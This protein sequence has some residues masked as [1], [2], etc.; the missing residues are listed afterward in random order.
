MPFPST[1]TSQQKT[2]IRTLGYKRKAYVLA[3][4]KSIVFQ[5]TVK[6]AI[7]D[8]DYAEVEFDTP[9]TGAYTDIV[10]GQTV[11]VHT[12]S[13]DIDDIVSG[14]YPTFAREAATS[15]AVKTGWLATDLAG[16]DTITVLDDYRL[17][18]RQVRVDETT[19][20]VYLDYDDEWFALPP[21]IH[22]LQSVYVVNSSAASSI[23]F[24]PTV[25]AMASGASISTY[26]WDVGDGTITVGASN[27]KDITVEFPA[28]TSGA[29]DG[30]R[31][32]S[33]TVTDDNGNSITFHFQVFVGDLESASWVVQD[34]IRLDI[35]SELEDGFIG[36]L[37]V[38][39]TATSF[40]DNQHI[41]VAI[42]ETKNSDSDPIVSNIAFVGRLKGL[43]DDVTASL[44][45]T[46]STVSVDYSTSYE[47]QGYGIELSLLPMPEYQL[48]FSSAASD[49]NQVTD[50]SVSR[51]I[52]YA[53]VHL[54]T[55]TTVISFDLDT[56]TWNDYQ[57]AGFSLEQG[58]A[59]ESI[60]HIG[61]L[62]GA[63]MVFARSGEMV[64][65]Q[66]ARLQ[67]TSDRNGLT[68]VTDITSD[69]VQGMRLTVPP[70]PRVGRVE[71]TGAS[72]N[73]SAEKG[74]F[75]RAI[76]PKIPNTTGESVR[77]FDVL[78]DADPADTDATLAELAIITANLLART[79]QAIQVDVTGLLDGYW[80]LIAHNGQW[81]T[82]TYDGF[83]SGKSYDSNTRWILISISLS[84]EVQTDDNGIPYQSWSVGIALSVETSDS[85][86][87]NS[88]VWAPDVQPYDVP[89]MSFMAPYGSDYDPSNA[90]EDANAE[91]L[92]ED[93]GA[94]EGAQPVNPPDSEP[95]ATPSKDVISVPLDGTTVVMN[96]TTIASN[97]YK[98]TVKGSG[99]TASA[100][101]ETAEPD[102]AVT[103]N[104]GINITTGRTYTITTTGSW[105]WTTGTSTTADGR[106]DPAVPGALLP[107]ASAFS[108]IGKIGVGGAWFAIGSN[109][110]FTAGSTG[111]LY[112]AMNDDM[113]GDNSGTLDTTVTAA[114]YYTDAFFDFDESSATAHGASKGIY[115]QLSNQ[116]LSLTS[117]PY[118][119]PAHSYSF[120]MTGSGAK[121]SFKYQD[122]DYSENSGS[123]SVTIEGEFA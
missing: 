18:V 7:A 30:W 12:D 24:A 43:V 116:E 87:A 84:L 16:S 101:D 25:E 61:A 110:T 31:W 91:S 53:L 63:N 11:I 57:N 86:I 65:V 96:K 68:T 21:A 123:L 109:Y 38:G 20:T 41:T 82:L 42:S 23:S 4:P 106:G 55:A 36:S 93:T 28:W 10:A 14:Q 34:V 66:D 69:D 37:T 92:T 117:P 77:Q 29:T 9:T 67:G 17:H 75:L 5:A 59:L 103:V 1:L 107:G 89:Q 108:L 115:P 40:Y 76:A 19:N 121:E 26:A 79:N 6:D 114:P 119:N 111:T 50:L 45:E 47:L 62:V 73:T 71:V 120:Y 22:G 15:T 85:G 2:D 98:V 83:Q 13:S 33:L 27:Q 48:L 99:V 44:I 102:A 39:D 74:S 90:Y 60:N 35:G 118:Y 100:D 51:A 52:W 32:V 54:T 56:S 97:V 72:F 88:I 8:S 58:S 78:L 104:T 95:T 80:F 3:T 113:F 112:L 94:G 64:L 49:W 122:T 81:Y 105:D 46:T 70:P